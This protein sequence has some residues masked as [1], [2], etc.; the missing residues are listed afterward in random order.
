M[1][2]LPLSITVKP[3]DCCFSLHGP[4]LLFSDWP[5]DAGALTV[6]TGQAPAAGH[7]L[8][9]S[10]EI[11]S[12]LSDTHRGNTHVHLCGGGQLDEQDVVVD[13]EAVV[14]GVLEHLTGNDIVMSIKHTEKHRDEMRSRCCLPPTLPT[15]MTWMSSALEERSCSPRITR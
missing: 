11:V 9:A 2:H 4:P 5:G 3:A 1:L 13:G 15:F 6:V 7:T 10:R 12:S 14:F 8:H